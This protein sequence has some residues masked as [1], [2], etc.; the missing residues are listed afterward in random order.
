MSPRICKKPVPISKILPDKFRPLSGDTDLPGQDVAV[1]EQQRKV[2]ISFELQ[3]APEPKATHCR[4]CL[5]AFSWRYRKP[6]VIG[7]RLQGNTWAAPF[8]GAVCDDCRKARADKEA[9]ERAEHH[10]VEVR[11]SHLQGCNVSDQDAASM[12]F[13][14]YRPVTDLQRAAQATCQALVSLGNEPL[15]GVPFA[16]RLKLP[17]RGKYLSGPVGTGKTHLTTAVVVAMCQG[18]VRAVRMKVP[19]MLMDM[20]EQFN[21]RPSKGLYQIAFKAPAL[22]LDDIGTER[23]TDWATEQ[24]FQLIDYRSEQRLL[25]LFT[26]NLTPKQLEGRL[27]DRVVSRILGMAD[28]VYI[29]GPD[30]RLKR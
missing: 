18:L 25:T 4:G 30:G 12:T 23:G 17:D 15:P 11:N 10:V 5:R 21:D 16:E 8:D 6:Y 9:R 27:S 20:K 26:T 22:L 28:V 29:D 3:L 14:Q 24:I 19:A 13:E 2:R 7:E 1:D